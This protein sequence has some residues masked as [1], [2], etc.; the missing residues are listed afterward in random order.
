MKT[1]HETGTEV[2][3]AV[4]E[5][6]EFA[7]EAVEWLFSKQDD[8]E[9]MQGTSLHRNGEG[10]SKTHAAQIDKKFPADMSHA[11]LTVMASCYTHTQLAEAVEQGELKLPSRKARRT[12]QLTDEDD[13]ERAQEDAEED[14]DED[15]AEDPSPVVSRF[16]IL[17]GPLCMPSRALCARVATVVER[18]RAAG[19]WSP[20]DVKNA[21]LEESKWLLGHVT[22]DDSVIDAA[23]YYTL[24]ALAF[25]PD[26]DLPKR[27]I[28]VW[29]NSESCWATAR[30]DRVTVSNGDLRVDLTFPEEAASGSVT[31]PDT[32][33]AYELV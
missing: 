29:W 15:A 22:V 17:C 8:D 30:V 1:N 11:E 12:L 10:L 32:A 28:R 3:L 16:G 31:G 13:E 20:R 21:I 6:R 23:L 25:S 9:R 14:A 33:F 26:G 2:I 24:P 7:R 5:N 18:L 19:A 27:L 4:R